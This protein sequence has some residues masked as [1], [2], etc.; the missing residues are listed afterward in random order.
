MKDQPAE[1]QLSDFIDR[2]TP[3]VGAI[4]RA[5]IARMRKRLPNAVVLVYDNYN[6]LAVGFGTTERMSDIILSIAL[7]PRWVSLFFFWGV[8]LPDPHKL[9]KGS[10]KQVRYIVL[11][12]A[13]V[14]DKPTVK[15]LIAQAL[16]GAS[17]PFDPT[18]DSRLTIKSISKKQRPRRP[19]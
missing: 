14:L 8:N 12:S 7:Y 10:G 16:E 3:E 18:V 11:E 9:L 19:G 2:Y 4:A 6:A 5:A 13:D 17:K 1:Q 15:K